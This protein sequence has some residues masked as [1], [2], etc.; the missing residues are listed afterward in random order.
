MNGLI[1][2]NEQRGGKIVKV[3]EK[4]RVT[5]GNETWEG[6]PF[7][8]KASQRGSRSW[9]WLS[10]EGITD[11]QGTKFHHKAASCPQ[12]AWSWVSDPKMS[13]AVCEYDEYVRIRLNER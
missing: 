5:Q 2:R 3:D 1:H 11:H 4:E 7:A 9:V 13:H 12:N 6:S 10:K 8:H